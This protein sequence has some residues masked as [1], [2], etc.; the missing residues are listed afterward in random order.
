MFEG[1]V[2]VPKWIS[3]DQKRYVDFVC[4]GKDVVAG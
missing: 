3:H 2:N 4:V 1:H